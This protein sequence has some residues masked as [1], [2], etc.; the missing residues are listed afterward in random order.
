MSSISDEQLLNF[1]PATAKAERVAWRD[2]HECLAVASGV[3]LPRREDDFE[4]NDIDVD[5]WCADIIVPEFASS[6]LYK[7]LS[8]LVG[9]STAETYSEA[10][11]LLACLPAELQGVAMLVQPLVGRNAPGGKLVTLPNEDQVPQAQ[12]MEI[13]EAAARLLLEQ[14]GPAHL[15]ATLRR[16]AHCALISA[17]ASLGY[18]LEPQCE[19]ALESLQFARV[20]F[21]DM[22]PL[23]AMSPPSTPVALLPLD[24]VPPAAAAACGKTD[25]AAVAAEASPASDSSA[26]IAAAWRSALAR[27]QW[28]AV[29]KK[30]LA[31]EC[32]M[33]GESAQ[34]DGVDPTPLNDAARV[35]LQPEQMSGAGQWAQMAAAAPTD[36]STVAEPL[37]AAL[38]A[39]IASMPRSM[40][41]GLLSPAST[42]LA[43]SVWSHLFPLPLFLVVGGEPVP[44]E[45]LPLVH[46]AHA[47]AQSVEGIKP[48]RPD[49]VPRALDAWVQSRLEERGQLAAESWAEHRTGQVAVGMLLALLVACS[50]M[51]QLRE[52][53]SLQPA[54]NWR[55]PVLSKQP[56]VARLLALAE[57]HTHANVIGGPVDTSELVEATRSSM[58][59]ALA[60][61]PGKDTSRQPGVDFK[62]VVLGSSGNGFATKA[63]D[64]D[65]CLLGSLDGNPMVRAAAA[66]TPALL[67]AFTPLHPLC[68]ADE[69]DH[70]SHVQARAALC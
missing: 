56:S 52:S 61:K 44:G 26:S 21:P 54:A 8:T 64:V 29:A 60:G 30:A 40:Q 28:L 53:G 4:D 46:E 15:L 20:Q 9:A 49:N 23:R 63:S 10:L 24:T 59:A 3:P 25:K 1:A 13:P 34:E 55:G 51:Q 68:A 37:L 7:Q 22:L 27:L 18:T 6:Q 69:H 17:A 35:L 57:A 67:P 33:A 66:A 19:D 5:A 48:Q 45:V 32:A 16:S 36:A 39:V 14:L 43:S 11:L 47:L 31:T 2:A 58:Q 42:A 41:Q 70:Q 65:M 38:A 50:R 62:I 12:P